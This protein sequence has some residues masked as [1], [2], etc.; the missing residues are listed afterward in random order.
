MTG[1]FPVYEVDYGWGKPHWVATVGV[2]FK[3]LVALMDTKD[4]DGIEAWVSMV[5]KDKDVIEAKYKLLYMQLA[6]PA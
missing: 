1:L 4:G 5:E 3:N 6:T 2:P